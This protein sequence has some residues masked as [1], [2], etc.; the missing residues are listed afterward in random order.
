MKAA[1][2]FRYLENYLGRKPFDQVMQ[3]YYQRYAFKH[4]QPRNIRTHIETETARNLEWFFD[5]LLSSTKDS[6]YRL[7]K[8]DLKGNKIGDTEYDLINVM[9]FH[10]QMKGP[11]SITALSDSKSVRTIWYEGFSGRMD[12]SFPA[13][14][15]DYYKL[16]A[17][18]LLPDKDRSNNI[19]N[20]KKGK[21]QKPKPAIKFLGALEKEDRR[22]LFWAPFVAYN[23]YDKFMPGLTF[24]NNF[25]PGKKFEYLL[26][27]AFS[28][29]ARDIV[30]LGE[31]N[32]RLYPEATWFKE[33]KVGM[34]A[35]RFHHGIIIDR[36]RETRV[37]LREKPF[38]YD[39]LVPQVEFK[40]RN[41]SVHSTLTKSISFKHNRI[42]KAP[43][44]ESI[45]STIVRFIGG[46]SQRE[47]Y[48]VNQVN[49]K[50]ENNRVINP[51]SWRVNLEQHPQFGKLH[52][53]FNYRFSFR[54]NRKG[55]NI[56]A[57]AGGFLWNDLRGLTLN[58]DD[59]LYEF[60]PSGNGGDQDYLFEQF[61]I[62]R[63]EFDGIAAQQIFIKD[64]GLR[65]R[66]N[67][68]SG[69]LGTSAKYM[70]ALNF[71]LD[72][73]KKLPFSL[74]WN[75]AKSGAN[76]MIRTTDFRDELRLFDYVEIG[77]ALK[78]LPNTFEIFFPLLFNQELES[79]VNLTSDSYIK[80][81]SFLLD[82]NNL[83]FVKGWRDKGLNFLDRR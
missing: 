13:G 42:E 60:K 10:N 73:P 57:F 18:N 4:P 8:A 55:F 72:F 37:T 47:D 45:D 22:Y 48:Y 21:R 40:L 71:D 19:I 30:G 16:D 2:A 29:G 63:Q 52:S 41:R 27:P 58:S 75:L 34:A 62:G 7:M 43:F 5:D 77:V 83:R 70:Y 61:F 81:V 39:Q 59:R 38:R 44:K 26:S 66:T 12:V 20:A 51:F 76:P 82:L 6:D 17:L 14:N 35:R 23:S 56:R 15:Y 69:D 32:Y 11:F 24:Y 79:A 53:E 49:F 68:I 64:G 33:I 28:S 36:D 1:M 80:K 25:L 67:G 54:R 50:L 31:I 46:Q 78:V 9:N 74:Y 65:A 3:S